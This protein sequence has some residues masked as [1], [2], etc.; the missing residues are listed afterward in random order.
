M[1]VFRKIWLVFLKHPFWDSSFYLI[2]DDTTL[3]VRKQPTESMIFSRLDYCNNLG[4]WQYQIKHLL[5]LQK[6]CASFILNKYAPCEDLGKLKWL[7]PE[8]INF[9]I[10]KL[11]FKGLFK[12]NV[13]E[14]LEIQVKTAILSLRTSNIKSPYNI[15]TFKSNNHFSSITQTHYITT[16]RTK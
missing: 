10:G 7:V 13:P 2:T 12:E 1:F 4:Y 16:F 3:P 8:R 11:I 15:Q 9:T 14:N 5:K 6:A